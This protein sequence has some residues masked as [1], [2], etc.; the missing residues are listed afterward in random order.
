MLNILLFTGLQHHVRWFPRRISEPSTAPH[1]KITQRRTYPASWDCNIITKFWTSGWYT[2]IVEK[3]IK[4]ASS[5]HNSLLKTNFMYQQ[6]AP[7][8]KKTS[9]MTE[10]IAT[11]WWLQTIFVTKISWQ[12]HLNLVGGLN[13]FETYSSIWKSS[14]IFGVN[15]TNIW[16]ATTGRQPL[17]TIIDPPVAFA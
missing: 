14:P 4:E 15:I 9:E 7:W 10:S 1:K 17:Q 12:K 11:Q 3:N 8:E 13:P 16:V 5:K 2:L 6:T